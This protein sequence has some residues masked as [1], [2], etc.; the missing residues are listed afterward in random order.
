MK[1]KTKHSSTIPNSR[2][3]AE[4]LILPDG[5]IFVQNLTQPM[6]RLLHSLNPGDKTIASRV[7]KSETIYEFPN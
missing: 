4:F 7:K 1:S 5:R 6:A 3:V 2:L